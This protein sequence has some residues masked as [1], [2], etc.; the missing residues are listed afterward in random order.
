M[1]PCVFG[2]FWL[3]AWVSGCPPVDNGPLI[4]RCLSWC[5]LQSWES[6]QRTRKS[7]NLTGRQL[8]PTVESS[9]RV[10]QPGKLVCDVARIVR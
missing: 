1:N 9:M 5:C 8:E 6:R 2:G 4:D 7:P 10:G 3:S